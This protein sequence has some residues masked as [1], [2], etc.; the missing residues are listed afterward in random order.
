MRASVLLTLL[1]STGSLLTACGATSRPCSTPSGEGNA[2]SAGFPETTSKPVLVTETYGISFRIDS[3]QKRNRNEVFCEGLA[4]SPKQD[5]KFE[6]FRANVTDDKGNT[7]IAG[8][9]VGGGR[10]N[11]GAVPRFLADTP[12]KVAFLVSNVA[13]D[14]TALAS[15][16]FGKARFTS[17]PIRPEA[18]S[19]PADAANAPGSAASATPSAPTP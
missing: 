13:T 18:L 1:L 15:L 17:V 16:S 3:C 8:V 14:A 10:M 2:T 6:F 9:Y 4:V 12:V 5:H 19:V 7:Y 11:F